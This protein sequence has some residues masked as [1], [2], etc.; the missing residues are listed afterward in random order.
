MKAESITDT[1]LRSRDWAECMDGAKQ[2]DIWDE[3]YHGLV[4]RTTRGVDD[5]LTHTWC[6]VYRMHEKKRRYKLGR[7]SAKSGMGHDAAR[8][9]FHKVQ[10]KIS[11]GVDVAVERKVERERQHQRDNVVTVLEVIQRYLTEYRTRRKR[12]WKVRTKYVY[13]RLLATEVLPVI[14]KEPIAAVSSEPVV[15][16]AEE[17]PGPRP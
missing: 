11:G 7:W 2:L 14:G 9:Q 4:L 5:H 12:E 1:F 6:V 16:V 13:G 17:H 8:R 15:S 10:A 3:H